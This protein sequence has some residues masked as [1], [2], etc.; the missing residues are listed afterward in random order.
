[1]NTPHFGTKHGPT[2]GTVLANVISKRSRRNNA[3]TWKPNSGIFRDNLC[4]L[5]DKKINVV[6]W[7]SKKGDGG[8]FFSHLEGC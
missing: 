3:R 6:A 5:H 4:S 1:M 8:W 7:S 2:S